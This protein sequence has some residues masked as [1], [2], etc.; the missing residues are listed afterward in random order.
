MP[1]DA[2]GFDWKS[3]RHGNVSIVI[4]EEEKIPTGYYGGEPGGGYAGR[5]VLRGGAPGEAREA[6][7]AE[8]QRRQHLASNQTK[9]QL[10][11]NF[12]MEEVSKMG[13]VEPSQWFLLLFFFLGTF[14]SSLQFHIVC[15]IERKRKQRHRVT[16]PS[17]LLRP[18]MVWLVWWSHP[19]IALTLMD[20]IIEQVKLLPFFY[21]K[22]VHPQDNHNA[23]APEQIRNTKNEDRQLSSCRV[24]R[25]APSHQIYD[26]HS[27]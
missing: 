19:H 15:T 18:W 10:P 25:K 1:L 11:S 17:W 4:G 12:K 13:M 22:K 5:D 24:Q 9:S 2:P 8:Q 23:S 16:F 7:P 20:G 21:G 6:P 14:S 27:Q 3:W 26:Q